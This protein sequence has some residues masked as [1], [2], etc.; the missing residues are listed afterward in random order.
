[1]EVI[2]N[3][4]NLAGITRQMNKSQAFLN[5]ITEDDKVP[6]MSKVNASMRSFKSI[7]LGRPREEIKA[8]ACIAATYD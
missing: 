2:N 3:C 1:M 4:S 5:Q 8:E 7:K 6:T